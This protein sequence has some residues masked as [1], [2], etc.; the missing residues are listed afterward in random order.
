[1]MQ[2]LQQS[3]WESYGFS[4]NPF[5][6]AA[7]SGNSF[8]YLPIKDAFVQRQDDE[9]ARL[10]TNLL[11]SQGGG[12]FVLEGEVGVGKTTFVNYHKFLWE[13]EAQ[14]KLLTPISEIS[15]CRHWNMHDFLLNVLSLI[16]TK[17][18]LLK[19]EKFVARHPLFKELLI[20]NKVY[21]LDSYQVEASVL[22]VGGGIGHNRQIS[23]PAITEAQLLHYYRQSV[24]A[25]LELGYKGIILHFD[26]LEL[27][28][29]ESIAQAQK[30]FD[31]IRDILQ[32]ANVYAIFVAQ[33]GFFQHVISPLPRV[34]SIF[35]G[36]PVILK[37]LSKANTLQAIHLRYRM[38]ANP[39]MNG[40]RPVTD[41]FI[42]YLYDVYDGQ[43]RFIMDAVNAIVLHS[44][45]LIPKTLA[46]EE[47][48]PLLKK[49]ALERIRQMLSANE[50]EILMSASRLGKFTNAQLC[51]AVKM[52]K[53][54]V[55]R[56]LQR[57]VAKGYVCFLEKEGRQVYYGL[58]EDGK[59]LKIFAEAF[60]PSP[61]KALPCPPKLN[62]RQKDF[63]A[64][65]VAHISVEDYSQKLG[66]S[67]TTAW[68]DLGGLE[69]LGLVKHQRDGKNV[70][71][72]KL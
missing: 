42:E 6:T 55:N 66:V 36:W 4:K 22:G 46:D 72:A 40:I 21:Q 25:V 56:Y 48:K 60:L 24:A 8:S 61:T 45:S 29:G 9:A 38:L 30:V 50:I 12:R 17:V 13:T 7:L 32:L 57:L 68:R 52:Q 23:L 67:H 2:S 59:I 18:L 62:K 49:I 26:N 43:I 14:D 3:L 16:T 1:M 64:M 53:Q 28:S 33:P 19:G 58:G 54:N 39:K 41:S 31:E 69:M 34:R 47:A 15:F 27:M 71:Y 20:L 63:L 11:R 5:D 35:F 65:A 37:P 10:F 51:Q 70:V 44:P